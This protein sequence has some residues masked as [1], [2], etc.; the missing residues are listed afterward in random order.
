MHSKRELPLQWIHMFW[1]LPFFWTR[2]WAQPN[3]VL[4]KDILDQVL[5]WVSWTAT[6]SWLYLS[7]H[8]IKF[9]HNLQWT[10]RKIASSIV[11]K[12]GAQRLLSPRRDLRQWRSHHPRGEPH[13]E[14][15]RRQHWPRLP[16]KT[17][18]QCLWN[19]IDLSS[20]HS[21]LSYRLGDLDLWDLSFLIWKMG[22]IYHSHDW[23]K[24]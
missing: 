8:R 22:I 7:D 17:S 19:Q 2:S 11:S 1:S 23:P 24:E 18:E 4:N 10:W 16:V 14:A 6:P 5:V 21:S 12:A 15:A 9:H 20:N 3:I 13:P